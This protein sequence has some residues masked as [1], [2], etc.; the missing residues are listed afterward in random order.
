MWRKKMRC[1]V[2]RA[3]A[4]EIAAC[5]TG[6]SAA[7]MGEWSLSLGRGYSLGQGQFLGRKLAESLVSC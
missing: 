3:K 4:A 5:P 6:S 2:V 7:E 1:T